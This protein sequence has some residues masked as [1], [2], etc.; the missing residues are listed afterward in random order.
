[1][2]GTISYRIGSE[3]IEAEHTTPEASE[4]QAFLRRAVDSGARSAVMEV[5]SHALDLHRADGL[6]FAVAAFTN[7]TQDHLDYHQTMD[8]YFRS[9]RMLFDGSIGT[10]PARTVINADDPR[11]AELIELGGAGAISYGLNSSAPDL[12]ES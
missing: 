2:M 8:D 7:L 12:G 1:M 4:I 11:G 6:E 9:K 5:S 10:I 3:E